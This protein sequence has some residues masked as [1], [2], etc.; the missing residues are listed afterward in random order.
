II[1]TRAEHPAVVNSC[2]ALEKQGYEITWL[3]V[4]NDGMPDLDELEAAITAR[5]ILIS[6]M[7]ANHET[8]VLL[9]VHEIGEIAARRR[10]YFHCDAVQAVGKVPV[11]FKELNIGLL[12]LSG[13]KLY[14]PKGV[15]ALVVRKGVKVAPL[16]HGG[17]Q[18]RNRRAGTENVAGIVALGKA[19]ELAIDAMTAESRRIAAL[20]DRL[21]EGL[22]STIP[23]VRVN[24]HK[25]RRLPNTTNLSFPG[26]EADSLLLNLDL[27]GIAASS[28]S[29]CSSG[30][31]KASAVLA[32]MGVEPACARGAVRFSLGRETTA[33]EIDYVLQ[34]MPEIVARLR[35]K[36]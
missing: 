16:I 35:V 19:C 36:Q 22:L 32:A 33:E 29:A 24:G 13:H 5:T 2:L 21:E 20:R 11:D 10:I 15:G 30:T 8:G 12:A 34:V 18:E 23:D 3:A 26:A 1:T 25:E 6:L 28:G 14:A 9:P 17:P 4:D 7:F 31:L 27:Q